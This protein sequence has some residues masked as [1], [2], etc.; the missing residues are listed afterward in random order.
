VAHELDATHVP[1]E[2]RNNQLRDA[3]IVVCATSAPDAILHADAVRDALEISQRRTMFC[4][5]LAVPRDI[6]PE[7]GKIPGVFLYN[8]DDLQGIV[9]EG[10]EARRAEAAKAER[11]VNEQ[12]ERFLHW[13]HGRTAV[14]ILSELRSHYEEVRLHEL[15]EVRG[16]MDDEQFKVLDK[17]TH[18]LLNKF[19]HGPTLGLKQLASEGEDVESLDMFRRV[20]G[21]NGSR[22]AQADGTPEKDR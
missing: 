19:L 6:A 15:N 7:V 22:S 11:I 18:R 12:A 10:E 9:L 5:D 17:V 4:V 14:P 13:F 20:F 3:S 2:Q 21:L 1:W 8:V 16:G